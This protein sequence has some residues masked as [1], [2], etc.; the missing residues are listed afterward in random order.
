MLT[1]VSRILDRDDYNF[2]KSP[3][4]QKS[5]IKI[6]KISEEIKSLNEYE[7]DTIVFD[8]ISGTPNSKYIDQFF[9]RGMHYSFDI[10]LFHTIL[11]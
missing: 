2:T 4:E 5:K 11:F 9:I 3:G 6:E 7:N 10:F 8:D 1:I